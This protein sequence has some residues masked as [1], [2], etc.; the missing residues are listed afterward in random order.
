[1]AARVAA[2]RTHSF[3]E[4]SFLFEYISLPELSLIG[5]CLRNFRRYERKYLLVN[6]LNPLNAEFNP[7]CHLLALLAAHPI[8]HVGRIRVNIPV[9]M[10]Q[11][12][13]CAKLGCCVVKH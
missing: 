13:L 11:H 1:M 12:V 7:I 9:E 5:L 4:L 3:I 2:A 6:P 8:F 10:M